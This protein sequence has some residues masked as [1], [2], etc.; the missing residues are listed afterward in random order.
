MPLPVKAASVA[1][2]PSKMQGTGLGGCPFLTD[3]G[4]TEATTAVGAKP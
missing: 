1:S 4:I 3:R 2:W